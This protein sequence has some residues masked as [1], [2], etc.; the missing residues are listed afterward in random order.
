L[1]I[2][3]I[4]SVNHIVA[5]RV[6]CTSWAHVWRLRSLFLGTGYDTGHVSMHYLMSHGTMLG[7]L[8]CEGSGSP[9]SLRLQTPPLCLG[10]LWCR[11]TS[12]SFGSYLLAREGSGAATCLASPDHAFWAREGSC[13]AIYPM[14]LRRL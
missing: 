12:H 1:F 3:N 14:A 11:H 5:M 8:V 10:G 13:A 4:A 2:Y 7:H 6:I 9:T